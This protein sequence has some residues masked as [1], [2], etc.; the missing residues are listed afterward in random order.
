METAGAEK[1]DPHFWGG[2]VDFGVK[3]L[4]DDDGFHV[5]LFLSEKK[6]TGRVAVPCP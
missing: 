6:K 4:L 1:V 2:D 3:N 5:F